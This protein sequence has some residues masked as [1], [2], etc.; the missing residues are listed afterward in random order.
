M[1]EIFRRADS[2]ATEPTKFS[3]VLRWCHARFRSYLFGRSF[4]S[5]EKLASFTQQITETF[6]L[7]QKYAPPP[8]V[9]VAFEPACAWRETNTGTVPSY[10]RR[11]RTSRAGPD[12]EL[13]SLGPTSGSSPRWWGPCTTWE[14]RDDLPRHHAGPLPQTSNEIL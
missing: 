3:H 2:S 5:L 10:C 4:S 8:P 9:D 6:F 14:A 1:Q 11:P 7:E 12:R 13:I